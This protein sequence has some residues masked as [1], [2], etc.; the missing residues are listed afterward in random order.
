MPKQMQAM[1]HLDSDPCQRGA[2]VVTE[3]DLTNTGRHFCSLDTIIENPK[4]RL[5]V[6]IP[7]QLK[8]TWSSRS[9][10]MRISFKNP[11]QAPV[12]RFFETASDKPQALDAEWGGTVRFAESDGSRIVVR[13]AGGCVG[14]TFKPGVR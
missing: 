3:K 2:L 10:P 8:G 11:G 9:T 6:L 12:I 1:F 5:R 4:L 7:T 14:V 13:T